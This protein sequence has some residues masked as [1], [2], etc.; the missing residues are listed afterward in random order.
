MHP[1]GERL[2][3]ESFTDHHCSS[4]D[5]CGDG[6][7]VQTQKIGHADWQLIISQLPEYR[8][9]ETELKTFESKLQEQI[10]SK[11]LKLEAKFKAYKSLSADTPDAIRK[12]REEELSYLQENL[13]KFQHEAQQSMQRKQSELL[14]AVLKRIA[15]AIS[16]VAE[17]N[18]Y[19]YILNPRTAGGE[20][21]LLFASKHNDV[22]RLVLQK[23]G[24]VEK[25][26]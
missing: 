1:E 26:E 12:D 25:R 4:I 16:Q 18:G 24:V 7:G 13:Q 8:Q 22:S 21:F 11:G 19:A 23:L 15:N 17:E 5:D 14:N 3:H 6:A 2:F 10:K 9:I 20:D